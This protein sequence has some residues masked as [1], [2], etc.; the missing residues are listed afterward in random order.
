M[1]S[2]ENTMNKLSFQGPHSLRGSTNRQ[3]KLFYSWDIILEN[4]RRGAC[5][6]HYGVQ[7]RGTLPEAMNAREGFL[8][9]P[10]LPDLKTK[11][12]TGYKESSSIG[13]K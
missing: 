10:S 12:S 5:T 2:F 7:G 1:S 6:R 4:S 9:T 3:T 11:S 13:I 8:K